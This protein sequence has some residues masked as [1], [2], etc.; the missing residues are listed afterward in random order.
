MFSSENK[1]LNKWVAN[2]DIDFVLGVDVDQKKV[3]VDA[4][5]CEEGAGLRVPLNAWNI[6]EIQAGA[7]FWVVGVKAIMNYHLPELNY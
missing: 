4:S 5:E 7:Y 3:S 1:K 2:L 6:L